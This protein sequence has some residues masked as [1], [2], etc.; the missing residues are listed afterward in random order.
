MNVWT[1]NIERLTVKR[2]KLFDLGLNYGVSFIGL[3]TNSFNTIPNYRAQEVQTLKNR[4]V[5]IGLDF[6]FYS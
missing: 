4:N 5:G 1:K 6:Y 2:I 3:H